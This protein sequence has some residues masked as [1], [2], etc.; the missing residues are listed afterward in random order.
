MHWLLW[1]MLQWNMGLQISLWDNY[2]IS[3]VY[4][5]RHG[6]AGS[7]G[8]SIFNFLRN[9]H[10]V[11]CSGC[12][13]LHSHQQC[14]KGSFFSTSSTAFVISCPLIVAIL[15]GMRWYLIVVVICISLMISDIKNLFMYLLTICMSVF[16]GKVSIQI[17]CSYFNFV[18][19]F[20][21]LLSCMGSLYILDI[22]LL[23]D[24]RFANIFSDSV[25]CLFILLMVSFAVLIS[26]VQSHLIILLL[27]PLFLCQIHNIMAK[28]NVKEFTPFLLGVL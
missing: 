22:N 2:L 14:A 12:N 25:G 24:L 4:I 6:I 20:Y 15:I 27:L 8:R 19:C 7:Y 1:I 28:D 23:S 11:F 9:I 16:F 18:I 17:L 10:A 3:F 26:L 13:S 5:H 21:Y